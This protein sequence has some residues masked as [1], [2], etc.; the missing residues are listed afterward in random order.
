MNLLHATRNVGG[1]IIRKR[2]IRLENQ[3]LVLYDLHYTTIGFVA[4]EKLL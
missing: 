4:R 1:L 2:L 3:S